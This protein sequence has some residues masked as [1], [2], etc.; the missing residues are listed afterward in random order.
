MM[1]NYYNNEYAKIVEDICMTLSDQ[2]T[3]MYRKQEKEIQAAALEFT[4]CK[5]TCKEVTTT[6]G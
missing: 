5:F 6:I 4:Y 3:Q 2:P 1:K